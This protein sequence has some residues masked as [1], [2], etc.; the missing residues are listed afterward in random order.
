MQTEK[1]SDFNELGQLLNLKDVAKILDV[2]AS[3]LRYWDKQGLVNFERNWQNDY[4]LVSL[5]TLLNLL[6]VL[7]YRE[8][9]I[10]IERIKQTS[11]MNL[12]ELQHLLNES[13]ANLQENIA[14]MQQTVA[15][16]RQRQQA[17]DRIHTLENRQP[18]LIY[19]QMPAIYRVNLL[20]QQDVKNYFAPMQAADL[21]HSAKPEQWLSGM[22]AENQCGEQLRPADSHSMPYLNGLLRFGRDDKDNRAELLN[23]AYMMGYR[24]NQ[25]ITQY[26]AAVHHPEF[27][28]CDYFE[29]WVELLESA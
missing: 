14:K 5:D 8:M 25:I 20:E 2:P 27:G 12:A 23:I 29:C 1:I 9:D 22:W 18:T 17:L 11:Q 26:L 6:D 4:R 21:L 3:T 19:R 10:P 7:D 13:E 28:L 15:K 16:I 24:P